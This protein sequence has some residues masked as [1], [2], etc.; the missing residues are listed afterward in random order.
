MLVRA[1]D[2]VI[3]GP[4]S[5]VVQQAANRINVVQPD[6]STTPLDVERLRGGLVLRTLF[7]EP[8]ERPQWA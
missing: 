8:G 7:P 4:Q 5:F 2:E 3:D 6:G 1:A